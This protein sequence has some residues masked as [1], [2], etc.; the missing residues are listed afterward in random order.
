MGQCDDLSGYNPPTYYNDVKMTLAN[1]NLIV[2]SSIT[3]EK[4]NLF[5]YNILGKPILSG[6]V[7]GTKSAKFKIGNISSGI[8]IAKFEYKDRSWSFKFTK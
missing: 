8:Y 7:I 4:G 3:I 5:V 6:K 1:D 2:E